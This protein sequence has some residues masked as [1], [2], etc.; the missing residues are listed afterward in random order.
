VIATATDHQVVVSWVAP[1][2]TGNA[3]IA[4]YT[5]R[6]IHDEERWTFDDSSPAT[7]LTLNYLDDG[8]AY[9]FEVAAEN[10]S[11]L[12]GPNSSA[13]P[14]VTPSPIVE[15]E[16]SLTLETAPNLSPVLCSLLININISSN[17]C[18]GF[19]Q[20]FFVE[21]EAWGST[22]S[23]TAAPPF[24]VP[25]FWMQ[26][27]VVIEES[28]TGDWWAQ[29]EA[30]VLPVSAGAAPQASVACSGFPDTP[31]VCG[32]SARSVNLMSNPFPTTIV[33]RS[34]VSKNTVRFYDSLLGPSPFFTWTE[35]GGR[36]AA[37]SVTT[38][39]PCALN[40]NQCP[41]VYPFNPFNVVW[42]PT[43]PLYQGAPE[44]VLVGWEE[45]EPT[46]TFLAGTGG[47]LGS[48]LRLSNGR[49]A[50]NTVC[51]ISSSQTE[52]EETGNSLQWTVSP[53][54]ATRFSY[55]AGSTS[56][57]VAFLPQT[58]P[59]QDSLPPNAVAGGST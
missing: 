58:L 46:A 25:P 11:R 10:S 32:R 13:S 55:L 23:P 4:N 42:N 8:L 47:S 27:M 9:R 54:G 29:P 7:T 6:A 36:P 22:D 56:E 17:E 48:A 45:G 14:P 2:D 53:G 35:P 37:H 50:T 57:G 20:D 39:P 59:C 33:V 12:T 3:P 26:N 38:T 5:V 34:V 28:A 52:T 16:N 31:G 40:G 19:Q 21:A 51:P 1:R 15:V 43:T 24:R 41:P 49:F 44:G 18:F 30:M